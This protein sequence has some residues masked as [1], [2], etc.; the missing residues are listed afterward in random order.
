MELTVPEIPAELVK[1]EPAGGYALRIRCEHCHETHEHGAGSRENV[2][3]GHILYGSRAAHCRGDSPY[4]F[5]G[6]RLIPDRGANTLEENA[7][8][9]ATARRVRS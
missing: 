3:A 4:N 7:I 6:Y 8:R 9:A 2:E 5:T 1:Y